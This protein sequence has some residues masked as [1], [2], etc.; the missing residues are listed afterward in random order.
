MAQVRARFCAVA[1]PGSDDRFLAVVG[2]E[3]D[4][5]LLSSMKTLDLQT[6]EWRMQ[7]GELRVPRKDQV[8]FCALFSAAC[9]CVG[10]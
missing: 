8:L 2:G 10:W 4:G 7:A 9:C 5:E 6:N 3:M 1:V